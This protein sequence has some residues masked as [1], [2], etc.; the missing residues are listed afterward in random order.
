[1]RTET[2]VPLITGLWLGSQWQGWARLRALSGADEALLETSG[3]PAQRVTALLA[4]A[5]VSMG[6]VPVSED[7]VRSLT[8]GDRERLVFALHAISFGGQIDV[9]VNCARDECRERIELPL[10]LAELLARV[11]EAPTKA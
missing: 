4:A 8:I 11:T 7:T 3:A 9:V 6:V 5:I 10:D 1:M 2:S